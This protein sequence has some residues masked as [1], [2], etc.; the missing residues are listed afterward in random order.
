MHSEFDFNIY[1]VLR[2]S[3]SASEL[4]SKVV[5]LSDLGFAKTEQAVKKGYICISPFYQKGYT[6]YAAKWIAPEHKDALVAFLTDYQNNLKLE[7]ERRALIAKIAKDKADAR[8]RDRTALLDQVIANY[9]QV[10]S[11]ILTDEQITYLR[12]NITS[13]VKT[14]IKT[15]ASLLETLEKQKLVEAE[16]ARQA[17]QKK[18]NEAKQRKRI[19]LSYIDRGFLAESDMETIA[20]D[21]NHSVSQLVF[22]L[23][24]K[25][26]G[27]KLSSSKKSF[28]GEAGIFISIDQ[29]NQKLHSSNMTHDEMVLYFQKHFLKEG[30]IAKD[31]KKKEE[32]EK[33]QKLEASF[34][35]AEN[36]KERGFFSDNQF[37]AYRQRIDLNLYNVC[38][39]I[40]ISKNY[41]FIGRKNQ[42]FAQTRNHA[43]HI[44]VNSLVK[45]IESS[46]LSYDQ[47]V[48]WCNQQFLEQ[49]ATS[50][51][52]K[53]KRLQD[54]QD[55]LAQYISRINDTSLADEIKNTYVVTATKD[56]ASSLKKHVEA[57]LLER[58][59]RE[60]KQKLQSIFDSFNYKDM[61]FNTRKTKRH[62]VYYCGPTNSGKTYQAF[63]HVNADTKGLYLSP[64]R[65]L[66]LEGCETLTNRGI[67]CNLVTGEER[68]VVDGA[69]FQSSTIEITPVNTK[70]TYDVAI[71]D[72]MGMLIDDQR[73]ASWLQA[74]VGVNAKTVVMTGPEYMLATIHKLVTE[75]L[76]ETIDVVHC[77]R[78]VPLVVRDSTVNTFKKGDALIVF[79]RRAVFDYK[80]QLESQGHSVS[81]VYGAL[82][83]EV[84]AEQARLFREGINDILVSTDAIAMGLNL[85]IH[86]VIFTTTS[87]YNGYEME[88]LD[89]P[90]LAQIAGRAGRYGFDREVGEVCALNRKDLSYIRHGMKN[91]GKIIHT[92]LSVKEHLDIVL[93]IQE[94]LQTEKLFDVLSFFY[95]NVKEIGNFSQ[96]EHGDK[97][98]LAR[99][100]DDYDIPMIDKYALC[101]APFN[102]DNEALFAVWARLVRSISNST[103]VTLKTISSNTLETLEH[104]L[105]Q[106]DLMR[107]FYWSYPD[108]L[109][110]PSDLFSE[111]REINV[112][113]E[114]KLTNSSIK[115]AQKRERKN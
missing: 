21:G 95:S 100:V 14:T 40:V 18:E 113:I 101:C 26:N 99:Y 97:L 110:N 114:S 103:T 77:E 79:S 7:A 31:K 87:K 92:T 51:A 115:K 107:W 15:V 72:E 6:R 102:A 46:D 75:Y 38:A 82:S 90:L 2:N 76:G 106:L 41:L 112:K 69:K 30:A 52:N 55:Y 35:V 111:I 50:R 58:A 23:F 68:S 59:K 4:L 88:S 44:S 22:G 61:F 56:I 42:L 45:K 98:I 93:I 47:T 84:R 70:E 86:R 71:I 37:Q 65:L 36:L 54:N 48:D 105:K 80:Y 78:K 19:L 27:F 1:L 13:K 66:A 12:A 63:S 49:E 10:N 81:V 33:Q 11:I 67:A 43:Q 73:G 104:R 85:P 64:L 20:N 57:L 34:K 32:K 53:A 108:F 9:Q 39:D 74:I 29:F 96:G 17:Q 25:N 62:F 3:P 83:P 24:A 94:L 5:T 16:R 28:S 60:Y 109:E 89:L 8:Q 91:F